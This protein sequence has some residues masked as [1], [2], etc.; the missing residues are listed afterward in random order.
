LVASIRHQTIGEKTRIADAREVPAASRPSSMRPA[1]S[2]IRLG[3]MPFRSIDPNGLDCLT[4]GLESEIITGLARY[5]GIS[6]VPIGAADFLLEGRSILD[7]LDIDYLVEATIQHGA[8]RVRIMARLIDVRANGEVIWADR[9]DRELI[10][11]LA[12]QSEIASEIVAQIDPRLMLRQGERAAAQ[13]ADYPTPNELVLQSIPAIFRL[14]RRDFQAAGKSLKIAVTE[15]PDNAPAHAWLAYWNLFLVGQG[16]TTEPDAVSAYADELAKRAIALDP[17][18]ARA[19]TLAG[20]VRGYLGKRP[21]EACTLHR[22]A[23]T[24]NPNLALAWCFFGL[25]QCYR[26]NHEEA[27][28]LIGE[29]MRL[30]PFD[31]HLFFFDMALTMPHLLLG[32]YEAVVEI[33]QRAIQLNPAFTSSYKGHLSALGHLGRK[34]EAAR[35]CSNLLVLEPGFTLRQ[36]RTRSPISSA[37]DLDRY[38]EGLGRA[39]VPQ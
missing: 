17:G 34:A 31:P 20:H 36:A 15:G 18:D 25:A 27:L 5:R 26:G 12:S 35:I 8:G 6:C 30:S 29:A 4:Q 16:W 38:V 39:G 1:S 37:A 23:I 24:L 13:R 9:F 2:G 33:S 28:R 7:L 22:R 11:S 32:N 19:L 21:D 14:E 3:I 10:D